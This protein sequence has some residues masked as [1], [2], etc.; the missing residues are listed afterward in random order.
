MNSSDVT[1]TPEPCTPA[2]TNYQIRTDTRSEQIQHSCQNR[3][4]CALITCARQSA[5]ANNTRVCRKDSPFFKIIV[6]IASKLFH[7]LVLEIALNSPL[8]M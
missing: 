4:P 2:R 7:S 3:L 5:R 8:V 1:H 6:A